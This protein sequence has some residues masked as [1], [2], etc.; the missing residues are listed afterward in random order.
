MTE[1][2]ELDYDDFGREEQSYY[3][4]VSRMLIRYYLKNEAVLYILGSR[5]VKR[6]NVIEHLRIQ[7]YLFEN[8]KMT[9]N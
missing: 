9:L 1:P 2:G 7:R 8:L 4:M 6:E 3:C 5:K